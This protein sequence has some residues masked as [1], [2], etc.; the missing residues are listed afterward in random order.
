MSDQRLAARLGPALTTALVAWIA[1]RAVVGIAWLISGTSWF[2]RIDTTGSMRHEG[3]FLWDGTY[4]R[5]LAGSGYAALPDDVQRFFPLYHLLGR[6]VGF[7]FGGNDQVGLVV[8]AN[9]AAFVALWAM[10]RLVEDVSGDRHLAARSVWWLALF[11]SGAVFVW[12]YSES[13]AVALGIAAVWAYR[14]RK[15]AV[16]AL[17]GVGVGLSR[18]VGLVIAVMFAVA[19][20]TELDDLR[21]RD[22]LRSWAVFRTWSVREWAQRI[23][24]VASPVVGFAA[25]FVWLRR[26]F[27][28]WD[29]PLESQRRFRAGWRD[30]LTRLV[31]GIIDVASGSADDAFNVV[32]ALVVIAALVLSWRRVPVAA[33]A[34]VAVTLVVTL[35][36]NN[37]D[38]LGRYVLCAF[39]LAGLIAVSERRVID[40]VGGGA[41]GGRFAERAW[42]PWALTTL[43]AGAML[44]YCLW[45]WSGRMIP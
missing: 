29:V 4:Y 12:S 34:Y 16:A 25:Y 17:F 30:P 22:A 6:W 27:G 24:V 11:P 43:S 19:L 41:G 5:D 44:V 26:E 42:I 37:I 28:S 15:F 8:V 14:S 9:A 20:L 36:A 45:A 3:R 10:Y 7:V 1:A 40:S 18:S 31:E 33:W 23:A 21:R 35:S 13:I 38:S 32:F 39:P 2:E